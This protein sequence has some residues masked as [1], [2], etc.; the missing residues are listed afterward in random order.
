MKA[1][2]IRNNYEEKFENCFFPGKLL[3]KEKGGH[4]SSFNEMLPLFSY[5]FA[6]CSKK[7]GTC[8]VKT[9]RMWASMYFLASFKVMS[10]VSNKEENLHSTSPFLY[11]EVQNKRG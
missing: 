3:D 8:N 6:Q 10:L 4:L 5:Y 2:S 9:R 7:E 1:G 11:T